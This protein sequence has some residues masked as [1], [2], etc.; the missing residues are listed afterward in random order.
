[1]GKSNLKQD[2]LLKK[3]QQLLP[4][5]SFGF[6]A[7]KLSNKPEKLLGNH[8]KDK[9]FQIRTKSPYWIALNQCPATARIVGALLLPTPMHQIK[10]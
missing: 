7:T 8:E 2:V 5:V 10:R 6:M 1:M 9:Y 3:K 4:L